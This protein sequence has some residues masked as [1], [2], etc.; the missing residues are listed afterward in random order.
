[1]QICLAV[2]LQ[3]D[4]MDLVNQPERSVFS[5]TKRIVSFLLSAVMA[6]GLC[7]PAFAAEAEGGLMSESIS[8][9]ALAA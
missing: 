2:S 7:V 8:A 1:M 9:A 6:A 3:I 4:I 5:M